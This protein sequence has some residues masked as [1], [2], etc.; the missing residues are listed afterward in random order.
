MTTSKFVLGLWPIAGVTTLG[1]T[2][3][4]AR[5]TMAAAIESGVTQFDT[6][7]SYGYDGESDRLLGQFVGNDRDRFTVMG[8]VG[9]RWDEQR[10]RIVDGSPE[11]LTQ[12]AEESLRRMKLERFDLLYLHSPDPNVP[13]S[14][15]A[16][17]MQ[18]LQQRGLCDKIGFCNMNVQQLAEFSAS[19]PLDAIQCPLN[20]LQRDN[21]SR[22]IDPCRQAGR[23]VYVFWTLMKGLLAGKITRDHV[24]ADGDSR[25]G[26]EIFQ[27]QSRQRAHDVIDDLVLLGN[28]I[29]QTV[30]QL[31]VGWAISQPG[32]SGALV[33]ARRP[34]QIRETVASRPLSAATLQRV[35][36]ILQTHRS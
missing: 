22:L 32:V 17:A 18:R 13:L 25:P 36:T 5:S 7:F 29:D 30:A 16:A 28:E 14:E 12:D 15:S 24:F 21:Q 20:L 6:A 26:Y 27:G 2:P 11:Q 3:D 4:D 34:D 10:R 23:A 8:K 9:Q 35:E 31:A 1:V 33:G 19:V